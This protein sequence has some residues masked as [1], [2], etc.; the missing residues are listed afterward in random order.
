MRPT[1]HAVTRFGAGLCGDDDPARF[2]ASARALFHDAKP[3]L[4]M[5]AGAARFVAEWHDNARNVEAFLAG[6]PANSAG[7]AP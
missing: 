3:R 1:T 4:E 7:N 2:L 5:Q 6:L